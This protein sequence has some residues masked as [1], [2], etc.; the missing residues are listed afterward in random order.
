MCIYI[1]I[2]IYIHT[3]MDVCIVGGHQSQRD[4]YLQ[5]LWMVL[6][7]LEGLSLSILAQRPHKELGSCESTRPE[8]V[9]SKSEGS[10]D[11]EFPG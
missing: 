10:M 4:S 8:V 1:Y 5:H 9:L 2:Y 3:H 7:C 11:S 6:D